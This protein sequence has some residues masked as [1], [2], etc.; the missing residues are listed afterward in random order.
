MADMYV[1]FDDGDEELEKS[2]AAELSKNDDIVEYIHETSLEA[3]KARFA[4][5]EE[6]ESIRSEGFE[7]AKKGGLIIKPHPES[8]MP[9]MDR[10]ITP[11]AD[12]AT[13][14]DSELSKVFDMAKSEHDSDSVM[15][16]DL[17]TD[18]T[19]PEE[20]KKAEENE[21]KAEPVEEPPKEPPKKKRG[22]PRKNPPP[23]EKAEK[24]DKKEDISEE[25]KKEAE[26]SAEKASEEKPH[27][28]QNMRRYGFDTN[29]KVIYVNEELDD[30]IKRNSESELN[31]LFSTESSE[32][33]FRLWR[34]KKK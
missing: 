30:G 11:R 9:Y 31:N 13:D 17:G 25:E 4:A 6:D 2:I 20:E 33:G 27:N 5:A 8:V 15:F 1:P 3:L 7:L 32:R 21:Q 29:T 22:R 18:M 28:E 19:K 12:I 26:A 23:E 24:E 34:K 10:E 16:S 14:S